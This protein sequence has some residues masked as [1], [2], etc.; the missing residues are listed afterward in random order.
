MQV[1]K[2]GGWKEKTVVVNTNIISIVCTYLVIFNDWKGKEVIFLF[3]SSLY[4][5]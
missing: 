1:V 5:V 2:Y 3:Q 4:K